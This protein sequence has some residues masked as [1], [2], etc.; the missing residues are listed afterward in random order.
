MTL[1]INCCV[2]KDS[3][4]ERL[5]RAALTKLEGEV[6]EVSLYNEELRPL[7]AETLSKRT[8]LIKAG[9]FSDKMFDYAKQFAAADNIVIAAPFWDLSFPAPLKTYI[10][11]IYITGIVSEYDT[12]GM[13]YGLCRAKR[14]WYVTTAG[15]PYIPEY[16]YG[17]I[18]SLAKNFFGIAETRLIYAELLDVD[19]S[20]PEKLLQDAITSVLNS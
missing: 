1:F 12:N 5:A 14:L 11:N 17:Y 8:E 18:E 15:G 6:C 20:D 3:R 4:T 9:S 7:S 2:R 16:S 10:E 19:G 13:P